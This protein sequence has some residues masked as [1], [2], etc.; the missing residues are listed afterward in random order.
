MTTRFAK[1][2]DRAALS[3]FLAVAAVP[4]LAFPALAVAVP[5]MIH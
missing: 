2:L 4:V 3:L 5:G 1:V